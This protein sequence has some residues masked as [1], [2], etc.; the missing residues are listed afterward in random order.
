MTD[1]TI[2][3]AIQ[4][5]GVVT[6]NFPE[7]TTLGEI[8]RILNLNPSL[9]FRLGGNPVDDDFEIDEEAEGS[10]LIGAQD[11]KGGIR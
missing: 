2:K 11:A 5:D 7:G 10:Y 6:K 4:G 1:V 9:E 3:I 8:R